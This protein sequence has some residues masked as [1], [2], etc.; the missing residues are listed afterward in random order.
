MA[1]LLATRSSRLWPGVWAEPAVRTTTREP[2]RSAVG[3]QATR[4]GAPNGAT[5]ATSAAS[6]AAR[7]SSMSTNTI[8]VGMPRR[9][10]ALAAAAPTNP[11]PT[12][13]TFTGSP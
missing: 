7:G 11:A 6:A 1:A 13:P 10:S 5:W 3:P 4:T 9:T 2:T 12:M 8:S